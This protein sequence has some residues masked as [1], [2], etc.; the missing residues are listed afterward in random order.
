MPDELLIEELERLRRMGE[1][2]L[3]AGLPYETLRSLSTEARQKLSALRPATLAQAARVPGVG[4]A[5]VQNLLLAAERWRRE[6]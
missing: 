6:Q 4:P 5:D 1:F 3:P 2:A